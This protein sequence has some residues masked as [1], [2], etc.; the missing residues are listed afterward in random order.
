MP[1]AEE[2]QV[3]VKLTH[4]TLHALRAVNGIIEAGGECVLEN[5]AS[6]EALLGAVAPAWKTDG[7]K[8]AARVWPDATGWHL[9]TDTEAMLDRTS[10]AMRAIA[11]A[12][13]KNPRAAMDYAACNA[14]DGE[15]VTP[16]GMD[17]WVV[18]GSPQDSVAKVSA[19]LKGLKVEV[20]GAGPAAFAEIAVV[21]AAL[22]AEEKGSVALWDLGSDQSTLVLISGAGVEATV[23]CE[24][25]LS[26]IFEAV[27][28]ALRLK[29]RGAGER[30]FFNET[31]DFTEPGPKV[32]AAVGAKLKAALGLLPPSATSP[33]L[34]CLG[35]T[36]KQAWFL[37]EVAS[38]AGTT[39][40]EPAVADLASGLGVSFSDSTVEA[41]FSSASAGLMYFVASRTHGSEAW[42][43]SWVSVDAQPEE[44]APPP[45]PVEEPEPEEPPAPAPA[46][47]PVA[48]P[49]PAPVR[50][51]PTIAPEGG[52]APATPRPKP[53]MG[54]KVGLAP[55][56]PGGAPSAPRAAPPA[57]RPAPAH[58]APPP[59]PRAPS[60]VAMSMA[61]PAPPG[62]PSVP[63]PASPSEAPA[64]AA[65]KLATRPYTPP[66]TPA[67]PRP[68]SFS[69]PG[70][71]PETQPPFPGM[72][73][74]S[75]P[76]PPS[77]EIA[78][79]VKAALAE[80]GT[81]PPM[82]VTAL[83]FEAIK[84]RQTVTEAPF[85]Q[86]APPK[87]K[88]GFYIG[89]GVAA[90]II[91]AVV[92][93][94]L[95]AK[96]EKAEAADRAQQLELAQQVTEERLKEADKAAK[97]EADRSSK[98]L[99]DAVE[100]TRKQTE[101]QTRRAVIE[102][103][104]NDRLAKLPGILL[105]AT[106]PPG[107][108]VSIDGAAPALSPVKAEGIA[109]GTHAIQITMA[110]HDPVALTAEIK[111]SKTT[112]LGTV[113]LQTSVGTI[114]LTSTPDGLD[115]AIRTAA[116]PMGAAVRT[117]RTPAT[118]DG[119][120]HG[121][122]VVTF[123]RPD[124]RDHVVNVTVA[125]GGQSPVDTKYVDGSLDLS[126]DPSG[127]WV[128]QDGERLGSTPLVIHDLTPKKATFML[129]LPGY[130]P[131]P[132]TCE[133]PEGQTL[134]LEAQLLRRDR[135]FDPNEVKIP[136]VN[137]E[138]PPPVLTAAQL[139]QGG[140]VLISFVVRLDGSV[141]D[142]TVEKA[143]DDEI[144]RR[145]KAA[146]ETWRFRAATASDNRFVDSKMEKEFTFPAGGR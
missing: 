131:T 38:A 47:A 93:F 2:I 116:N 16:D 59:S 110:G 121:D 146:V 120:P 56:P 137:Y 65:P 63:Q 67:D 37:R 143:S 41:S 18:T 1:K 69:R 129:T 106:T 127:A 11:S 141:S 26:S 71:L 64:P 95:E 10:D 19:A 128:D 119:I 94:V 79:K 21:T 140:Q 124:C 53:T 70:F 88:V 77:P 50:T 73:S 14:T 3:Y 17:K 80:A 33:M 113:A 92:A 7:I 49:A 90:A 83:P 136:P 81:K 12:T 85:A 36:G 51:R 61:P 57:P 101:E 96:M 8:A 97:E 5:K 45:A 100:M 135:V 134:K 117:G 76:L 23:P 6:V 89:L 43:P 30:L 108:S 78:A 145:C 75:P 102:E 40:W 125:K 44:V 4:H 99:A 115:F 123:S 22:R 32:G 126:S 112:D 54:P 66:Q 138:S 86:E 84:Q 42:L 60:P 104:E 31:Y 55:P 118:L 15:N 82:A 48:K 122:Y 28:V 139:K 114:E 132:V 34:A 35:L 25:G 91:F 111:G 39:P 142:V 52:T 27:Q 9:S 29:F 133:I 107:A 58:G 105:I 103:M 98:E 72:P 24:V 62:A 13:Q 74:S 46:P 144:G 130:D 68:P 87:S 20:D 109:P